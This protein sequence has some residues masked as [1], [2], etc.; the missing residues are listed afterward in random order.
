MSL[1]EP[2]LAKGRAA[3][4]AF[5]LSATTQIAL[6]P[7]KFEEDRDECTT[8]VNRVGV[9]RSLCMLGLRRQKNYAVIGE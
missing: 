1:E 5:K 8:Q 4:Q 3:G 9:R 2:S 6:R 7:E